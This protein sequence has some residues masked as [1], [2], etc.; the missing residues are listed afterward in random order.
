MRKCTECEQTNKACILRTREKCAEKVI[1]TSTAFDKFGN[2]SD[3]ESLADETEELKIYG[4]QDEQ[5]ELLIIKMIDIIPGAD[6][7]E[8]Y[9]LTHDVKVRDDWEL[10]AKKKKVWKLLD[11]TIDG[12]VRRVL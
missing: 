6:V 2:D 1:V 11:V 5:T 10:K 4:R 7:D 9:R 8:L 3:Y 12:T